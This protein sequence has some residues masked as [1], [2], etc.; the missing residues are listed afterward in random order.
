MRDD[1]PTACLGHCIFLMR[2]SAL[3]PNAALP[4]ERCGWMAG[5]T[6]N[7]P[8]VLVVPLSHGL[9]PQR[10]RVVRG[11]AAGWG[12]QAS[13]AAPGRRSCNYR[14]LSLSARQASFPCFLLS[15]AAAACMRA[16]G[17][18]LLA[19]VQSA[20][21][22][23]LLFAFGVAPTRE[24]SL[25]Q[26][27]GFEIGAAPRLPWRPALPRQTLQDHWPG[28][29]LQILIGRI[30][31]PCPRSR[32]VQCLFA[33]RSKRACKV[34]AKGVCCRRRYL[35][36]VVMGSCKGTFEAREDVLEVPEKQ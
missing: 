11:L 12:R 27:S 22:L 33:Y 17:L 32:G 30:G 34:A 29:L 26:R 24:R 36:Y 16:A 19:D 20:S 13:C 15:A 18:G 35:V 4:S 8:S 25:S 31:A 14:V 28:S 7:D 23:F 9:I 3:P 2:F 10:R 21:M 6:L 1:G 5:G